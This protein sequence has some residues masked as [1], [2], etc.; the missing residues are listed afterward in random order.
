VYRKN[1]NG[2]IETD[3]AMMLPTGVGMSV[4]D[5]KYYL[6]IL[7]PSMVWMP[8]TVPRLITN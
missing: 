1:N 5:N 3:V 7:V 8:G 4:R 6:D 2:K